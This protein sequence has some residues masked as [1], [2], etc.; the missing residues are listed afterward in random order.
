MPI[1][2]TALR[3]QREQEQMGLFSRPSDVSGTRGRIE[4]ER[5]QFGSRFGLDPRAAASKVGGI[6]RNTG[7]SLDRIKY[8]RGIQ[9]QRQKWEAVYNM[10]LQA[11]GDVQSAIQYANDYLNQSTAMEASA[12]KQ[13]ADRQSNERMAALKDLYAKQGLELE[14][15]FSD[16]PYNYANAIASILGS[17]I[18]IGTTEYLRRRPLPAQRPVSVDKTP[19]TSYR[20]PE[21]PD[22]LPEKRGYR[23][24]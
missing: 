9:M 2:Y 12:R 7:E 19:A 3:K 5:G 15:E 17:G 8:E 16:N 14:S 23:Y 10:A 24:G 18:G 21:T 4:S 6:E 1:D 13:E 20:Y 11:T 22:T